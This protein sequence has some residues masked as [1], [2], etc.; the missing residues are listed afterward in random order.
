MDYSNKKTLHDV[1]VKSKIVIVRVDYNVPIDNGVIQDDNRIKASLPTLEHLIKNKAKVVLLSHLGRVKSENDKAKNT[2]RPIAQNLADKLGKDVKFIPS[3]KG[4]EVE[5]AISQMQ[6]GEVILLENTRFQDVMNGDVVNYESKRHPDLGH[7]WAKLG[8][9]FVNDAFG[10]SHRSHASNVGIASNMK[11]SC[12]G[13]L[14]QNEIEQ[15]GKGLNK[16]ESPIVSIVGGAKVSDKIAVIENLLS[17]SDKVIIGG[18]MAYTFLKAQGHKIGISLCEED[19]LA[20]A[21]ELLEKG[22]SKILL[23]LDSACSKSFSNEEPL[24]TEGK[25]VPDGYMG[26]DIGPKSIDMFKAAIE[27]AKTVIWNGPMGVS[28]LS[29]YSKGTEAVCA[30]IANQKGVFSIIGGGDSA[31]AAIKL[32]Y[33]EKFTHIST[34]GGASLEFME[35]KDLPGISAISTK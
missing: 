34:G 3:N 32:G 26:L 17:K 18:G 8:D 23:P 5:E 31:A 9:V 28:E 16:P 1:D 20:V 22:Q 2:L 29:N 10:T 24:I 11:E 33:Q 7:Y 13:F 14:I 21:I 30:S 35:G 15:L 19:K 12:V 27:G 25:E 4:Q 6:E